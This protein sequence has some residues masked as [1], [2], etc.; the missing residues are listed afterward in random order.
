[1]SRVLVLLG[2]L[3]GV[4][5]QAPASVAEETHPVPEYPATLNWEMENLLRSLHRRIIPPKGTPK[6][7]VEAV[8]GEGMPERDG[9][10]EYALFPAGQRP[11]KNDEVHLKHIVPLRVV[12]RNERV[13]LARIGYD[14]ARENAKRFAGRYDNYTILSELLTFHDAFCARLNKATWNTTAHPAQPENVSTGTESDLHLMAAMKSAASDLFPVGPTLDTMMTQ[15]EMDATGV[16]GLSS[17]EKVAM[18]RWVGKLVYCVAFGT[19]ANM[20]KGPTAGM[21]PGPR[22]IY[23]YQVQTAPP[24][25]SEEIAIQYARITLTKMGRRMPKW[26]LTRA[27]QPPSEA[28]DGTP[29]KYFDRFSFRPTEGRVHFTDRKEF[30]TVQV[31]LDGNWIECW[32]FV[33]N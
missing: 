7:E 9:M 8:F 29:D 3:F 31:R 15:E 28:P 12:Y 22:N 32:R 5:L 16:S 20:T 11:V 13:R 6:R 27:D 2:F 14:S 33:G 26:E 10:E 17:R 4:V 21:A 19:I 25:L 24:M 18:E 30:R 1:M 23:Q